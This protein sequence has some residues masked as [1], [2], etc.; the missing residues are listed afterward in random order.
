[1][2]QKYLRGLILQFLNDIYPYEAEEMSI[3]SVFYEYWRDKDI[4]QALQYLVDKGY[5]E[6]R[7]AKHPVIKRKKL[8][9][10]KL[11]PAGKDLLEG[12][13]EDKGI[14]MEED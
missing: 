2:N 8:R 4:R 5:V 14:I 7:V 1:V 3:I 10:Y 6:E 12:T 13:T 9:F 11:L